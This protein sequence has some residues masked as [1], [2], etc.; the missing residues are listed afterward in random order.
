MTHNRKE[1][2]S[3]VRDKTHGWVSGW[4]F[5]LRAGDRGLN[6]CRD[7]P[8]PISKLWKQELGLF[9][10]WWRLHHRTVMLCKVSWVMIFF[11]NSCIPYIFNG[12]KT[13]IQLHIVLN[14]WSFKIESVVDHCSTN[15][16]DNVIFF[17]DIDFFFHKTSLIFTYF[18]W[19]K[20]CLCVW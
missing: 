2:G 7:K 6:P 16:W 20:G 8:R 9:D 1:D 15:V 11:F 12:V 14:L 17:Q 13:S 19:Y 10:I 5:A 3:I 18:Y 4:E